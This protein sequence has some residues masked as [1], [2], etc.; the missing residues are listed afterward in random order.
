M[1]LLKGLKLTLRSMGPKWV[2]REIIRRI[3]GIPY[4]YNGI[5]VK[6]DVTFRLIRMLYA[7][8][9]HGAE[10]LLVRKLEKC[11]F[12]A[13]RIPEDNRPMLSIWYFKRL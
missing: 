4:T 11:G 9:I 3:A 5:L 8:E 13:R 2:A 7:I 12:H 10:P 1:A 6:D